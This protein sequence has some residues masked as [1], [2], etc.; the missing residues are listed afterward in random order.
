MLPIG[1]M[2]VEKD[3]YL[4]AAIVLPFDK[5]NTTKTVDKSSHSK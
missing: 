4:P 3:D 2:F 1:N 5:Y